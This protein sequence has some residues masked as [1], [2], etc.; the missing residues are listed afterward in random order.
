MRSSSV[1]FTRPTRA[2][3]CAGQGSGQRRTRHRP[4]RPAFLPAVLLAVGG[5]RHR[6]DVQ[7]VAVTYRSTAAGTEHRIRPDPAGCATGRPT[8]DLPRCSTGCPSGRPTGCVLELRRGPF[9]QAG[10]G[11][12]SGPVSPTPLPTRMGRGVFLFPGA[13]AQ[14]ETYPSGVLMAAPRSHQTV[15]VPPDVA[16]L[17]KWM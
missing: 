2:V 17:P 3:T 11:W 16:R 12:V 8:G 15:E 7:R 5:V 6:G 4:L 9:S 10:A 13:G 1:T 14:E